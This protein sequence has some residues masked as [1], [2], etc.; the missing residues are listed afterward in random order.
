MSGKNRYDH[1]RLI[2]VIGSICDDWRALHGVY[3]DTLDVWEGMASY[4]Q[5][6]IVCGERKERQEKE[7]MQDS[8]QEH[9]KSEG[10]EPAV[11]QYWT[12]KGTDGLPQ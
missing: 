11:C 8:S 4:E 10:T 5:E 3:G 7:E 1:V 2:Y 12:G 9:Q 6:L